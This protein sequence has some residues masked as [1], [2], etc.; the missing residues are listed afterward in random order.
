MSPLEIT[1]KN[2]Y[3]K[4]VV[5]CCS[6]KW[7]FDYGLDNDHRHHVAA[8]YTA[9]DDI[10]HNL[11]TTSV[12]NIA[13]PRSTIPML[14]VGMVMSAHPFPKAATSFGFLPLGNLPKGIVIIMS[15][16]CLSV[17]LSV[18][19]TVCLSRRAPEIT[20]LDIL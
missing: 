5:I 11:I 7:I 12:Q 13:K 17:R 8:T 16:V 14:V 9:W 15:S 18:C 3:P 6:F 10:S 20:F 1:Q 4:I 2:E 19:L